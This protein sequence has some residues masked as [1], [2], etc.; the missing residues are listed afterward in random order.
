MITSVVPPSRAA[1]FIRCDGDY[2]PNGIKLHESYYTLI[3]ITVEKYQFTVPVTWSTNSDDIE[4]SYT[5]RIRFGGI[6]GGGAIIKDK[7][8]TKIIKGLL[9]Q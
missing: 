4:H 1:S 7:T 3:D 8:I 5:C 9:S 2:C 6:N